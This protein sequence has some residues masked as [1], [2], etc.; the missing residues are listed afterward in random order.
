MPPRFRTSLPI[1]RWLVASV[2]Q[3][4]P[5][6]NRGGSKREPVKMKKWIERALNIHSGDLGRGTL[7]CA[8]LFLVISSYVI[9]KVAG[10]ALVPVALSGETACLRRYFQFRNRGPG[11]GGVRAGGAASRFA[12]SADRQHAI[13]RQQLRN[14]LGSGPTI[15]RTWP[16]CFLCSISG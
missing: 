8:C 13:F 10:A 5:Q 7:L 4:Q 15:A 3:W 14:I 16:G 1:R 2:R 12:G 6:P 9:G 11:G